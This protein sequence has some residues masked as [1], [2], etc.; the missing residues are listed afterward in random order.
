MLEWNLRTLIYESLI[1]E[2]FWLRRDQGPE[3]DNFQFLTSIT[4]IYSGCPLKWCV[5]FVP[6]IMTSK[7]FWL[8]Q[9]IWDQ[10]KVTYS[11]CTTTCSHW[12]HCIWSLELWEQEFLV[13]EKS[14]QSFFKNFL[15]YKSSSHTINLIK[16]NYQNSS[17]IA[18]F[19]SSCQHLNLVIHSMVK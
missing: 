12:N 10:T 17:N 7:H 19:H 14:L 2:C 11:W 4:Y 1:G 15:G 16:T 13:L 6:I 5:T 8:L 9:W 18:G 3:L